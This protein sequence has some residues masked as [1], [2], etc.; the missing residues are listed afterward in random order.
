MKLTKSLTYIY[1]NYYYKNIDW[2]E[3]EEDKEDNNQWE[4]D[5]DDDK[6]EDDF[7]Q[8]LR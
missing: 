5:W 7:S 6:V 8:Q 2:D 1:L 3:G 4:N